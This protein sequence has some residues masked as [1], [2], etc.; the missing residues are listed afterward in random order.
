MTVR[1]LPLGSTPAGS[2]TYRPDRQPTGIGLGDYPVGPLVAAPWAGSLIALGARLARQMPSPGDS[3]L[4]VALTVPARDLAAV[5]VACGWT[6]TRPV[7]ELGIPAEV[8]AT[9]SYCTPVRMVTDHY[10]IG[11]LFY[12]IQDGP[13]GPRIR[14]GGTWELE[15]VRGLVAVP[16]LGEHRYGKRAITLPGTLAGMTGQSVSWTARQCDPRRDLAILGTK[17]WLAGDMTACVGWGSAGLADEIGAILLPDTDTS[18]T[19]A[20]RVYAAQLVQELDLPPNLSFVVLDGA[21]AIR[22]LP[23]VES[24]VVVAVIDRRTADEAPSEMVMQVRARSELESLDRL[25]WHPP[26]GIEAVAFRVA[27]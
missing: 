23:E 1:R 19:W 18:P 3:Q 10:V 16:D 15:H 14:A 11:G 7:K 9:L 5:L 24:P 22:W 13:T 12:G 17:S 4:V 27:L 6:L 20:T 21:S 2:A 8:A 26:A 25:G